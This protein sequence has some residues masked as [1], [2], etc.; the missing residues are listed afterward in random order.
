[1]NTENKNSGVLLPLNSIKRLHRY[2]ASLQMLMATGQT[3]ATTDTIASISGT[4]LHILIADLKLMHIDVM[5]DT[6]INL[7]QL[8]KALDQ[9]IK[10]EAN[11]EVIVAGTREHLNRLL[12]TWEFAGYGFQ[13]N[14][15]FSVSDIRPFTYLPGCKVKAIEIMEGCI[16]KSNIK[17]AVLCSDHHNAQSLANKMV[18]AGISLIWNY[19][20][21]IIS[22]PLGVKVENVIPGYP[23]WNGRMTAYLL[24]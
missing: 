14:A 22:V 10:E 15:I 17:T 18:E 6:I 19:S 21:M 2:V 20:P 5:P 24:S 13:I 3:F 9:S 11:E 16:R 7:T 4:E 12:E 8:F 23:K 1:M